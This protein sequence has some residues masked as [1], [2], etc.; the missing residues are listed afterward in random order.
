M[1][2]GMREF[3]EFCEEFFFERTVSMGGNERVF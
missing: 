2:E 3:F 1:W